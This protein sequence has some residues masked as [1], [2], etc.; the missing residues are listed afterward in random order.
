MKL[1]KNK[2]IKTMLNN[3]R[4]NWWYKI[5]IFFVS[6]AKL[7]MDKWSTNAMFKILKNCEGGHE[8]MW[9]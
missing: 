7:Q 9:I 2:M 4:K 1:M 6:L 8:K 3:I 5:G